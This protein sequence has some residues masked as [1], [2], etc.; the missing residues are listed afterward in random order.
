MQSELNRFGSLDVEGL[1]LILRR[2]ID[3][4]PPSKEELAICRDE[5]CQH[6]LKR[7][8]EQIERLI[9]PYRS[10]HA[11]IVEELDYY[12]SEI[13]EIFFYL[14]IKDISLTSEHYEQLR[15]YA[16]S[17][18]FRMAFREPLYAFQEKAHS[19][20]SGQPI[21]DTPP[22][23]IRKEREYLAAVQCISIGTGLIKQLLFAFRDGC[24][25]LDRLS[26]LMRLVHGFAEAKNMRMLPSYESKVEKKAVSGKQAERRR[27]AGQ[28]KR[29]NLLKAA[30]DVLKNPLKR[31]A[32][33]HENGKINVS[34][35]LKKI[36]SD[37]P[38]IEIR[39]SQGRSILSDLIKEKSLQ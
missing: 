39:S 22:N 26:D 35:L 27:A 6:L 17:K 37:H 12:L 28:K 20:L 13:T 4:L 11:E 16:F 25:E 3:L 24:L 23:S 10:K 33:Y 8:A 18:E 36:K 38:E 15:K 32:C 7:N 19:P 34:R 29:E 21:E 30:R 1:P 9:Q 2:G 14:K 31:E 5:L